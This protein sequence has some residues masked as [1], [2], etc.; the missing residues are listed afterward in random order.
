MN[1]ENLTDYMVLESFKEVLEYN[2]PNIVIQLKELLYNEFLKDTICKPSCDN[3]IKD[4]LISYYLN[5]K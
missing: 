1:R 4:L 3:K 5:Q 2:H